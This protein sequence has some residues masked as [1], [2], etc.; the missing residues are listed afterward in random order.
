MS[1][2]SYQTAPPRVAVGT[3]GESARGLKL[4]RN[5]VPLQCK[6]EYESGLRIKYALSLSEKVTQLLVEP[7]DNVCIPDVDHVIDSPARQ[8]VTDEVPEVREA[9]WCV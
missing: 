5:A 9:Y 4:K 7:V 2:T 8:E 6:T 1:P 3:A